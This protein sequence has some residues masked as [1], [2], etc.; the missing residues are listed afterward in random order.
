MSGSRPRRAGRIGAVSGALKSRVA[1]LSRQL[2][3]T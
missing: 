1:P 3:L 2:L